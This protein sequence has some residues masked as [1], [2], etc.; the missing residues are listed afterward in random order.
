MEKFVALTGRRHAYHR[1]AAIRVLRKGRKPKA[2]DR[3]LR[4]HRYQR[5]RGSEALPN[6]S[7]QAVKE[8]LDRLCK[9]TPFLEIDS[10]NEF[11]FINHK[12]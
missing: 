4:T 7:Q 9:R 5:R 8:A 10:D 1:K 3:L 2:C 11:A 6:R 12:L